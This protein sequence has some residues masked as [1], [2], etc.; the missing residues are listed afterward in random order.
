MKC[1]RVGLFAGNGRRGDLIVAGPVSLYD[2]T[3]GT[4]R[5]HRPAGFASEAGSLGMGRCLRSGPVGGAFSPAFLAEMAGPHRGYWGAMVRR[6][7]RVAGRGAIS[8]FRLELR[9]ALPALQRA[10][11]QVLWPGHDGVGRGQS[12]GLR[13]DCAAGLSGLSR[14]VG[15]TGRLRGF[16]GFYFGF[17]VFDSERRG[18]L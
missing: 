15:K 16:G 12:G 7:A 3:T 11:L 6:L 17:L 8:R 2:N 18:Q 5:Q 10:A 4:Q 1:T 9:A 13:G 14:R